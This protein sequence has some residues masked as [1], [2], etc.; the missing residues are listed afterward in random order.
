MPTFTREEH[1]AAVNTELQ[2]AI[3]GLDKKAKT[4]PV[5]GNGDVNGDHDGDH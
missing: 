5:E 1:A 4:T 3:L 2:E